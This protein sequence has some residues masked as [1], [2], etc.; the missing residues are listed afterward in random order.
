MRLSLIAT[1]FVCILLLYTETLSFLLLVLLN[2][3]VKLHILIP[4]QH[5]IL[6][7]KN[8]ALSI[9]FFLEFQLHL[10]SSLMAHYSIY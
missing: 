2:K 1:L 9:L 3:A 4:N 6:K 8:Y 7:K 10:T 5:V